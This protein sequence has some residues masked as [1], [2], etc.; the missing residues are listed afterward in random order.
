MRTA[1]TFFLLAL[2]VVPARAEIRLETSAEPREIRVGDRV[3]LT[4]TVTRSSDVVLMPPA[5][6]KTLGTL[7]VLNFTAGPAL[8]APG[9]AQQQFAYTLTAFEVGVA[10][11]PALSF[12]YTVG[13]ATK[14][15]ETPAIPIAVKSVLPPNAKD[16]K[17]IK[18]A[19]ATPGKILLALLLL[20]ALGAGGWWLWNK[21][22]QAVGE[23]GAPAAPPR[24]AGKIALEALQD[25]ENALNE[26]AK[27][28]YSRLSDILRL[29]V[30]NRYRVPAMDRTTSE[31]FVEMRRK[32]IDA[33]VCME[34]REILE[35]SD[36]VKFA[37]FEPPE[38]EK[39]RDL[40][41][42]RA[43]VLKTRPAPP[44]SGTTSRPAPESPETAPRPA[45]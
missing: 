38:E 27:I 13:G 34:P 44:A 11:I 10:T 26:P 41:R 23:A 20:A 2:A 36:L 6:E 4:C 33:T 12:A 19:L 31:L 16:I 29:Y 39:R 15:V 37:K 35:I 40:E 3:K 24:P 21:R 45:S 1:G 28:F 5:E 22:R 14:T 32:G 9:G 18:G 8:G 42:T 30:E 7:E 25:L 17:D 43:F